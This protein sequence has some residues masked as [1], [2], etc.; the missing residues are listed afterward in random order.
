MSPG[1]HPSTTA[2]SG[3]R[4]ASDDARSSL[5]LRG[6]IEQIDTLY[7]Q[8]PGHF[9]VTLVAAGIACNVLTGRVAPTLLWGWFGAVV[10]LTVWRFQLLFR[11][12]AS[13]PEREGISKWGY[14]Y[15]ASSAMGGLV[16][17]AAAHL[18][19]PPDSLALQAFVYIMLAGMMAGAS[20][21]M[22]VYLPAYAAF[23]LPIGLLTLASIAQGPPLIREDERFA[24]GF[25]VLLAGWMLVTGYFARTATANASYLRALRLDHENRVLD[26]V[27]ADRINDIENSNKTLA[28]QIALREATEADLRRAKEQLQ[29]ALRASELSI[30]D[31]TFERNLVYLDATWASMLGHEPR[32]QYCSIEA[33]IKLV[34]P[35]DLS[36]ARKAQIACLK[37]ET[38]EYSVEHRVRA[39]DG[40]WIWIMS[41]GRVADRNPTGMATRMIGT[42]LNITAQREAQAHIETLNRTLEGKL[43]E[44][45]DANR[46]LQ[47]FSSMVSHD[48]HAP[49]R[50][51]A[52]FSEMLAARTEAKLDEESLHFLERIRHNSKRMSALIDDLL[53]FARS[54]S[55][56]LNKGDVDL[57][58]LVREVCA[59]SVDSQEAR[60]ISW[61]IASLPSIEA[62]QA[63]LK[64]VF[65]NLIGNA[66][67]FTRTRTGRRIEIGTINTND[68]EHIVF[69]RDNG[70][71]FDPRYKDKLFLAFQRLHSERE[72]E[73]TGVGLATVF[74]IV[75]RHGGRLWADGD[76]DQGASFFMAIPATTEVT[77]ASI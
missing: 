34:H 77:Q 31:W 30:W 12:R 5:N 52:G 27:L 39:A 11:Y 35:K 45:A 48:L 46:D 19:M 25:G 21:S 70:V 66:V 54:T 59:E 16:W 50:R 4:S 71:G 20:L 38:E 53:E 15:I 10:V 65:V 32:A 62:D 9:L 74:R 55:T 1:S 2:I 51:I 36:L 28:A 57:N 6:R 68:A 17:G 26:R 29:L 61:T 13:H 73:G 33:L 14:L 22:T 64:V 76:I 58:A 23:V 49:L 24:I 75:E 72:F 8:A 63:L 40:R 41:R 18:L 47:N 7:R 3:S 37:G 42:N 67:K 56:P 60:E 43:A 69:V 44:L